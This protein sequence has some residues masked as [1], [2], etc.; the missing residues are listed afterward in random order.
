MKISGSLQ[1]TCLGGWL[2][3]A[4]LIGGMN[5]HQFAILEN[6]PLAGYSQTIKIL[7]ANLLQFD[8]TLANGLFSL[9]SQV[10]LP[11]SG[12]LSKEVGKAANGIPASVDHNVP[13]NQVTNTIILPSLTGIVH[14]VPTN[15]TVYF[16]ALLNGQLCRTKDVIDGFTVDKIS[17]EGV[18]VRRAGIIRTI[19][20]PTPYYS[21]DQGN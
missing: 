5:I 16:Q 4:L 14:V 19:E 21:S 10:E 7:Q 9:A 13:E 1:R 20:S 3:A 8:Q 6:Q 18:V 2:L 15:G 17:P 12:L 11:D